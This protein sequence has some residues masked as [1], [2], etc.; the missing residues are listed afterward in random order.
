MSEIVPSQ[1][2]IA[3][4]N[5]DAAMPEMTH[6]I[7]KVL[8][9]FIQD[10]DVDNDVRN[11]VMVLLNS[12]FEQITIF[13]FTDYH[14]AIEALYDINDNELYDAISVWNIDRYDYFVTQ[15]NQNFLLT[16]R[17]PSSMFLKSLNRY[18]RQE[19]HESLQKVGGAIAAMRTFLKNECGYTSRRAKGTKDLKDIIYPSLD[20]LKLFYECERKVQY[21]SIEAVSESLEKG[22]GF[23]FCS[24]CTRYHQGRSRKASAVELEPDNLLKRYKRTWKRYQV[25]G[26][27]EKIMAKN[28]NDV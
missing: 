18:E 6:P 24:H 3:A 25:T 12:Y 22:N 16:L 8:G 9:K 15:S 28:R 5:N 7:A 4:S 10:A 13:R 1:Q 27:H 21:G 19:L 17:S 11:Y 14:E 20:K 23:Y 2:G 26:R